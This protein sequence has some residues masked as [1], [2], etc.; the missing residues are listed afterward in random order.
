MTYG[1]NRILIGFSS[2]CVSVFGAYFKLQSFVFMPVF[3][4][5]NGMI[6]IVAFNYGAQRPGP[7]EKDRAPFRNIC[8]SR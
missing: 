1:M 8:R 2:V 4:L 7:H 3:G 6:P 5:T